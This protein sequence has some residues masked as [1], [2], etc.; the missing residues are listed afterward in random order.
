MHLTIQR[1]FKVT[2]TV[3]FVAGFSLGALAQWQVGEQVFSPPFFGHYFSLSHDEGWPPL[4]F[5]P[6]DVPV[7]FLGPMP[8]TTNLAFAYDDRLLSRNGQASSQSNEDPPPVPGGDNGGGP[9]GN[10]N[11]P[12][13]S[14]PFDC[15]TNL[16][17]IIGP[18]NAVSVSATNREAWL[19]LTNT[20]SPTYYQLLTRPRV[21]GPP[22]ELGEIVQD[23]GTTHHVSFSNVRTDDPSQRF[24]RGAG[25][26][27]I[28]SI[29]LDPDSNLAVEPA[30]LNDTEQT[31]K[32]RISLYPAP[33]SSVVVVYQVSGSASNRVDYT[34]LGN[35]VT[36]YPN[37]GFATIELHPLYDTLPEFDESV[38]LTLVLT[39]GYVIEPK[40][41]S[42]TMKIYDPRPAEMAVAIHDSG[43]TRW[44][45]LST[46]N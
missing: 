1:G 4:P 6:Y 7:Y 15:G 37:P 41:A 32:F 45:G 43:W 31:G 11:A 18:T 8:G 25:G 38:T 9:G 30:S 12:P 40:R 20:H 22:W 46:T 34:S 28:A 5:L 29:A 33:S 17:L 44:F 39:N 42:A 14:L 36:V 19:V 23:T 21:V 13:P 24:F 26:E 2:L 27:R 16:C 3:L 35:T 10:T